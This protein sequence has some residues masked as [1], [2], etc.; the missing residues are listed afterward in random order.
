MAETIQMNIEATIEDLEAQG[1]FQS[2]TKQVSAKPKA[3]LIRVSYLNQEQSSVVLRAPIA[4]KD[5]VAGFTQDMTWLLIPGR[6]IHAITLEEIKAELSWTR[7]TL[8]EL[9]EEKLIGVQLKL[10]FHWPSPE[11]NGELSGVDQGWLKIGNQQVFVY[12]TKSIAV[13]KL[14]ELKRISGTLL[15]GNVDEKA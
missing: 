15:D 5:F 9:L 2:L 3:K 10:K 8:E 7:S 1:Y 13:E 6:S 12:S 4:G 14:S 11:I